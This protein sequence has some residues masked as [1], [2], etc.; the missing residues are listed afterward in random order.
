MLAGLNDLLLAL[1]VFNEDGGS[2]GE[3][4]AKRLPTAC[5][6]M[7]CLRFGVADDRQFRAEIDTLTDIR[8]PNINKLLA[9]SFNGP[10]RCLILELMNGG[11]LDARLFE[12]PVLQ[13]HERVRIL[14]GMARGLTYM[15]AQKPPVIHRDVKC[16]NVLLHYKSNGELIAKIS[17]FGTVRVNREQE[18]KEGILRTSNLTH[19]STERA[20][21]TRPFMPPEYRERRQVSAR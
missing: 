11:A 20:C 6:N 19:V 7:H 12:Q 16:A 9:V 14:L 18:E 5:A 17:D 13:W 1:Q 8:H 15:H 3:W 4:H 21:G 2:W 10:N